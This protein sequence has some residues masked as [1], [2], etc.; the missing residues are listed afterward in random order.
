MIRVRLISSLDP[1]QL[2]IGTIG[3]ILDGP[4][5][6]H[7]MNLVQWDNGMIIPMYRFEIEEVK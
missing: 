4:I 3:T 2:P 7:G 1:G 6:T 5:V